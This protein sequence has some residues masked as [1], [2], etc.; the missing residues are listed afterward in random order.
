MESNLYDGNC[1]MGRISDLLSLR[2]ISVPIIFDGEMEMPRLPDAE[3]CFLDPAGE[4]VKFT[5]M[6]M[7]GRMS[8]DGELR[9]TLENIDIV[10]RGNIY[11]RQGSA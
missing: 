1:R 8:S 11:D 5:A 3:F 4:F 6:Q 9:V 10:E 2:T 7:S